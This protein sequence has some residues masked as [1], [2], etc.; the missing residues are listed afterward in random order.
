MS[1]GEKKLAEQRLSALELARAL[2]NVSLACRQRG[3]SRTQFYEYKRWFQTHGPRR[4]IAGSFR[5]SLL[6]E[7]RFPTRPKSSIVL[8]MCQLCC[9]MQTQRS[10]DIGPIRRFAL[11]PRGYPCILDHMRQ[12]KV[13]VNRRHGSM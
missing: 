6:G 2:G 1:K 8:L 5:P 7:R 4:S 9:S 11:A 10:N 3:L 12:G 13:S